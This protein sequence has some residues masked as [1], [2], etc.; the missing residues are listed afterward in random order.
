M[1]A[2]KK[3]SK[4]AARI[5]EELEAESTGLPEREDLPR[6]R[7]ETRE[8]YRPWVEDA[9][10]AFDGEIKDIEINGVSCK[11]LTPAGWSQQT[12]ACIQYAY[13]G[14]YISGSSY[15]DLIIAAPLAEHSNCRIIMVDYRLSPEHPYPAPQQDMQRVYPILLDVY[16]HQRL[17]VCGESA[18]G[19]QALGLLLHI[20]NNGLMMPAC[21]ALLS[22]WCDLADPHDE[23]G[24]DPTLDKNWVETAAAWHAAGQPLDDPGISPIYGD[25]SGLPPT[26]ITSGGRDL[27]LGMSRRLAEKMQDAGVDCRLEVRDGLWHVY[28]FYPIPEAGQ[29]IRE[30]ADYIHNHTRA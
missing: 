4:D 13:G 22:P 5:L 11:Q 7:R 17:A 10:A 2:E 15:E 26:L 28:E 30:I 18:G 20:R 24:R 6:Y 14:G 1:G 27:L 19:N 23:E 3:I 25:L 8:K 12:D 9:L 16:G 21:A 29:S